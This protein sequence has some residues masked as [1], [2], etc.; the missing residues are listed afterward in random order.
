MSRRRYTGAGIYPRARAQVVHDT[1]H[2]FGSCGTE[3]D[4]RTG[5]RGVVC[6]LA[7]GRAREK[8]T[9]AADSK[10]AASVS[11]SRNRI[12]QSD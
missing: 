1:P 9:R 2:T 8:R 4:V 11:T 7:E 6:S 10:L 5:I 3:A 12:T